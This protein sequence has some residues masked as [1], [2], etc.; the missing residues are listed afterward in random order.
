MKKFD[1]NHD[2]SNYSNDELNSIQTELCE[3]HSSL[4]LSTAQKIK[5]LVLQ[6]MDGWE[7]LHLHND[8]LVLGVKDSSRNLS[9]DIY[10]G[11]EWWKENNLNLS[12]RLIHHHWDRLTFSAI[13]RKKHIIL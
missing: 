11:Y 7:V 12:L 1:Y 5:S 8:R 3:E 10:F 13:Q 6:Y 4:I 9:V 2:F